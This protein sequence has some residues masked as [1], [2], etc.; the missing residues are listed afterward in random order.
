MKNDSWLPIVLITFSILLMAGHASALE[1]IWV[2]R[3]ADKVTNWAKARELNA[4]QPLNCEGSTRAEQIAKR[5]GDADIAAIYTST[6]TRTLAT[7]MPLAEAAGVPISPDDRTIDPAQLTAFFAEMNER[8]TE[9]ST[10]LI[11]GHS[12]TVPQLLI[13]LGAEA[14]CY[15]ALDIADHD[16]ELL[17]HGYEGLWR[18][19]LSRPGC[20]GIERQLVKLD[21]PASEPAPASQEDHH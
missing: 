13:E 17:I 16:G 21:E 15:P 18:I 12:N 3:H 9:D 7:G 5:L 10:I 6:T 8:H 19:D 4:F 14:S 2:V 1:T 20:A 11:V